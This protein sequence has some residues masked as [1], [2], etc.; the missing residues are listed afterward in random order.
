M[1]KRR[2]R[3]AKPFVQGPTAREG[4][5]GWDLSLRL[6][7]SKVLFTTVL[8]WGSTRWSTLG[9]NLRLG[10]DPTPMVLRKESSGPGSATCREPVA[11]VFSS[12]LPLQ[13]W[14]EFWVG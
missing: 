7:N 6:S 5:G 3:E 9:P 14:P 8:F 10:Q 12:L 1:S 2:M 4:G 13:L 11:T